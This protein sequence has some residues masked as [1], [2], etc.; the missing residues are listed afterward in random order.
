MKCCGCVYHCHYCLDTFFFTITILTTKKIIKVPHSIAEFI[1][2]QMGRHCFGKDLLNRCYCGFPTLSTSRW[3]PHRWT[4]PNL[5]EHICIWR[6][7]GDITPPPMSEQAWHPLTK[8]RPYPT[9]HPSLTT[10]Y[11][12]SKLPSYPLITE[13]PSYPLAYLRLYPSSPRPILCIMCRKVHLLILKESSTLGHD[14]TVNHTL[15]EKHVA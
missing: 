2:I 4:S 3:F 1:Q 5:S 13:S 15:R 6:G 12:L 14:R 8:L 11:S 7:K 9:P 10:L